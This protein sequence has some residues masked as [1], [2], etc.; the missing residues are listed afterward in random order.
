MRL[1]IYIICLGACLEQ[2]N[3]AYSSDRTE[4]E[5]EYELGEVLELTEPLVPTIAKKEQ[6][7]KQLTSLNKVDIKR[8]DISKLPLMLREGKSSLEFPTFKEGFK[9]PSF[10][11]KTA[12][13]K[14]KK[15][16]R[17]RNCESLKK[18]QVF[19]SQELTDVI[20]KTVK[21]P[22]YNPAQGQEDLEEWEK[23]SKS[24]S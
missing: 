3:Y 14:E 17:H 13:V 16:P 22:V 21:N 4:R 15:L 7:E 24:A 8:R 20:V 9:L 10:F 2:L 11:I 5:E 18:D 12:E 6:L 1:L 23:S 19:H